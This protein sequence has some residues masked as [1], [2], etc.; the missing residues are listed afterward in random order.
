MNHSRLLIYYAEM[1][2]SS[3]FFL[4]N[5]YQDIHHFSV[6]SFWAHL[7]RLQLQGPPKNK[8]FWRN[9]RNPPG[10]CSQREVKRSRKR[11][12]ITINYTSPPPLFFKRPTTLLEVHFLGLFVI[13]SSC[14]IYPKSSWEKKIMHLSG[15]NNEGKFQQAVIYQTQASFLLGKFTSGHLYSIYASL[16]VHAQWSERQISI[17]KLVNTRPK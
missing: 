7:H 16:S 11:Q 1:I 10:F 14:S 12:Y 3:F 13:L 9:G 15:K 6:S 5:R 4:L 2:H 8:D 17:K